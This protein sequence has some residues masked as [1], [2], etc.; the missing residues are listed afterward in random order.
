[1]NL[2]QLL[3]WM[4]GLSC[5]IF[6]FQTLRVSK[7]QARGWVVV[8]A[9][10]LAI[11]GV[12]LYLKPDQAGLIGGLLWLMFFVAPLV[13]SQQVNQFFFQERYAEAGRLARFVCWLHP[14]DGWR[15]QAK[16]LQAM[17]LSQ[18]GQSDRAITILQ[19]HCPPNTALGRSA[20]AIAYWIDA[21]WLGMLGWLR[22]VRTLRSS[23]DLMTYYLRSLGETGDLNG[24]L[25]ELEAYDHRIR[26]PANEAN[27]LYPVR[28]YALAFCGQVEQVQWLFD[29]RCTLYTAPRRQFWL[30]TA[31]RA[32]G[33]VDSANEQ[34]QVLYSRADRPLQQAI[35]WRLSHPASP[36]H[37]LTPDSIRYLQ[38]LDRNLKQEVQYGMTPNRPAVR[39]TLALI[40]C[41]V[42]VFAWATYLGGSENPHVLFKL[43]ALVPKLA[44]HGEWWRLVSSTFLHLGISHLTMNMLG[45]YVLGTYVESALGIWRY[46]LVYAVSG[47][48]SMGIVTLLSVWEK[49]PVDFVVGA[50]GAIM[51]LIGAIA[52]KLLCGWR[53]DKAKVARERLRSMGMIIVLQTLF[54]WLNP[55]ICFACHS[56]GLILG[57]LTA[58]LLVASQNSALGHQPSARKRD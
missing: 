26:Q 32:A 47:V 46:L 19:T 40:G 44:W 9:A 14:A 52:A 21:D 4:V 6:L 24:M 3:V 16:L 38:R 36:Q 18:Q 5:G 45:L 56:S 48:G 27:R 30:A 17:A 22:S 31:Q 41:N 25:Q 58:W 8:C 37:I 12:L 1:M 51:G 55:Q 13:A 2:N 29:R 50:S 35:S 28:L 7:A 42:A 11:T 39:A 43:G 57:F 10:I 23:P 33:N 15:E 49:S 20:T 34:L 53:K 54:D